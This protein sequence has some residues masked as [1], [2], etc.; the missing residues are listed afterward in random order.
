M[1]LSIQLRSRSLVPEGPGHLA[2]G[3]SPWNQDTGNTSPG[4]ATEVRRAKPNG[5]VVYVVPL[6]RKIQVDF[7]HDFL[8]PDLRGTHGHHHSVVP[9]T[10]KSPSGE[11]GKACSREQRIL[12]DTCPVP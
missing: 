11:A 10:K 7:V 4:G 2:T 9:L 8:W 5:I 3:A 12:P 6:D 1:Y